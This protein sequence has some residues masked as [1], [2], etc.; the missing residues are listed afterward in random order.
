MRKAFIRTLSEIA[1][2]DERVLLLTADLGYMVMEVFR[3]RYPE[4]FL[5]VGVAEQN[6]VGIAT[7]LAGAGYIPFTY[8][9]ATFMSLRALE[10]IRNGPV[11][12]RLP[13]RM[14]GMGMGFEYGHA[15]PTHHAVEDVAALRTLPG[16]AIVVPADPAQA[17]TA[18]RST[19]N[20]AGPV[21]YSLGKDDFASVP[22]LDG[23]FEIGRAVVIREGGDLA[24]AAMGSIA[25]QAAAAA[26][27]LSA[28]NIEAT[29]VIVSSFHPDPT[30]DLEQILSRHRHVISVEAQ[31]ASGGLGSLIASVIASRGLPCRLWPMAV[32]RS[33]D[34]ISGSQKDCWTR[35]GL[36]RLS[37]LETAMRAM[38]MPAS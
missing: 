32:R 12:H 1:G 29:V 28:R 7:G 38:E 37:I 36:D 4:R 15:G 31:A 3:D 8:S 14:V 33:L 21:Y 25:T 19:W 22:G 9:I 34:G 13:V 18:L 5:N 20:A 27:E 26:E 10:F 17:E 6:M 35:H 2:K 23:R 11:R 24:I 16:L 30:D